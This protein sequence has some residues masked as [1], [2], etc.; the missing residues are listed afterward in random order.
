MRWTREV[1]VCAHFGRLCRQFHVETAVAVL[2]VLQACM[3]KDD[4]VV[5]VGFSFRTK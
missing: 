1:W 5:Y 3:E 4:S 2:C